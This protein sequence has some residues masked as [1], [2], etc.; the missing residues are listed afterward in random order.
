MDN[1]DR[2]N[3]FIDQLQV[4]RELDEQL[5]QIIDSIENLASK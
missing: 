1:Q 3:E 2:R 5:E 4:P